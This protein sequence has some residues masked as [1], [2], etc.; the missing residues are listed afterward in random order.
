MHPRASPRV[1]HRSPGPSNN[2]A[3]VSRPATQ[4]AVQ[5]PTSRRTCGIIEHVREQPR[6]IYT[7]VR[8]PDSVARATS[9]TARGIVVTLL[10]ILTLASIVIAIVTLA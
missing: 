3:S 5:R 7:S 1:T 4:P 9:T 2:H 6:Q 10:V 8:S